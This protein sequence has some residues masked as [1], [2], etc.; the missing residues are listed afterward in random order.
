MPL[1]APILD[2][3]SYE[4]LRDELLRR[5]PVYAPEWTDLNAA[6]PGVTLLEL[7]AFLGEG[8][9]YRFN[10]IPD[11]TKLAFLRLLDVPLHAARPARTIVSIA[12]K[13]A[14]SAPVRVDAGAMAKAGKVVFET[15]TEVS[16]VPVELVAAGKVFADP[17]TDAAEREYAE[18]VVA[19]L[20]AQGR[21]GPNDVAVHYETQVQPAEPASPTA[22]A[23]ALD[24][25]VDGVLWVAVLRT[26][27]TV[28]KALEGALLSVGFVPDELV[29]GMAELDPCPGAD[30]GA[31]GPPVV[32]QISTG[33]L[34]GGRPEYLRLAVERDTTRG[35][36][37][38]GV[39]QLRLPPSLSDMA[40]FAGFDPDVA[41]TGQLP[42]TLEDDELSRRVL[43][44]LRAFR[45]V[46]EQVGPVLWVGANA[47][48]VEQL[49]TAA[50]EFLGT[51]TADAGQHASLANRQVQPGSLVLEVE[52][53]GWVP[54]REVD[55]F[56]ASAPDD[57]HY[58][59]DAESGTIRFGDGE[60]GRAPQLGERIRA[61]SYRHGGGAAGNVPAGALTK[62]DAFPGLKLTSPLPAHGGED[63]EP[64][65]SALER[66]P[67]ELRRHDRAVTA[68][69]FR[70]LALQTPGAEVGRAEC[71]PRFHPR[72]T[73]IDEFPGAVT[74]VVWPGRD[75]R[76]PRA[77]LPDRSL[78][79]A[80]CR[81]LDAR[82]LVTTELHVVPPTYRRVAVS[83]GVAVKPGY[84]I[85]GVRRWVELVVRQYLA[86]LPPYGPSGEGWPLG[87][88]VHGA[89]LEAAALQVEGV[90]YLEGLRLAEIVPVDGGDPQVVERRTVELERWEVP[91]LV[92]VGVGEGPPPPPTA[93]PAPPVEANPVPIPVVRETC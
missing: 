72:H 68:G 27:Q 37:R 76:R 7:F 41:G 34:A 86:P 22:A 23:V 51:G 50:P 84:G 40:V 5:V 83:I 56:H 90:E 3:R 2:D 78:L 24:R 46:G 58:V 81:Q 77:P 4:Q 47:T 64:V 45:E 75:P 16:V 67:A 11:A 6:D 61:R 54:W 48:E 93:E 66:V 60:R 29:P 38:R 8:L 9:L 65:A 33:R 15:L 36:S 59:L 43:F 12:P 69:D 32:W 1:P 92:D 20:R 73:E 87:R 55:G 31:G 53:G 14:L 57:R 52:E 88:R 26:R 18:R 25:A 30:S 13:S 21:L 39:V 28:E 91:E 44:W 35:L 17:P 79:D 89:E 71:L 82:R 19:E 62:L 85:E 42:P 80:V 74:V 70:E 10:Q 63:A 49:R